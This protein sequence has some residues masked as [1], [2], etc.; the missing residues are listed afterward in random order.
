V[1]E[2]EVRADAHTDTPRY[3]HKNEPVLIKV[4]CASHMN[5]EQ[6]PGINGK[7]IHWTKASSIC[8]AELAGESSLLQTPPI[9]KQAWDSSQSRGTL[10]MWLLP[11]TSINFVFLNIY[12]I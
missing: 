3:L 8:A 2:L 6:A 11:M 1:P 5:P 10:S 4:V 9:R 12:F 7:Q